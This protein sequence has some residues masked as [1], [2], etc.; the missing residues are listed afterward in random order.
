MNK[1]LTLMLSVV[2]LTTIILSP[3]YSAPLPA[4]G[5]NRQQSVDAQIIA[6]MNKNPIDNLLVR[7]MV[8]QFLKT[9]PE[10]AAK[11]FK[12]VPLQAVDAVA[13][14]AKEAVDHF[15]NVDT[16]SYNILLQALADA[17][18]ELQYAY[19][20]LDDEEG[21]AGIGTGGSAS[22]NTLTG[23]AGGGGGDNQTSNQ[24]ASE[25]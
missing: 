16:K 3:A 9:N 21:T 12:S 5:N 7:S 24:N 18:P 19:L 25:S 11:F 15:K 17:F 20:K 22:T 6:E 4:N 13:R 23:S 14:G 8:S 2:A 1:N 10:L